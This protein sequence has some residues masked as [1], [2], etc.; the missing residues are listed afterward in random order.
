MISQPR[1]SD[2]SFINANILR[3]LAYFNLEITTT[4][5]EFTNRIFQNIWQHNDHKMNEQNEDEIR[6]CGLV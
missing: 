2:F 3:T 4:A 5:I 6:Q 1:K